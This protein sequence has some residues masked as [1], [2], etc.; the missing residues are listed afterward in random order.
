LVTGLRRG[1]WVGPNTASYKGKER[2]EKEGTQEHKKL[3]SPRNNKI[4]SFV[5]GTVRD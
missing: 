2:R 3:A 4:S 5:E 1:S